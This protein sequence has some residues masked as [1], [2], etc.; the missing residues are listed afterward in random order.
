M[1]SRPQL[2][3]T[4]KSALAKVAIEPQS[5]GT[6]PDAEATQL[7][8]RDMMNEVMGLYVITP[9]GQLE[10]RRHIYRRG[11]LRSK[12]AQGAASERH[13]GSAQDFGGPQAGPNYRAPL[14]K[15]QTSALRS[16]WTWLQGSSAGDPPTR[17]G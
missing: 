1:V 2:S 13:A 10:L 4:E 5:V 11:S 12:F 9:K 7:I 16:F 3:D 6:L 14:S 17:T 8:D 15:S